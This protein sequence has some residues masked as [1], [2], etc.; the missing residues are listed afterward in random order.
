MIRLLILLIALGFPTASVE[1]GSAQE[2]FYK[3]KNIRIIVGAAAGGGYDTYSRTSVR[4]AK[5]E[6]DP[7]VASRPRWRDAISPAWPSLCG[8]VMSLCV[9]TSMTR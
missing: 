6:G 5:A 7:Q 8:G 9:W 3:D 1:L 2:A 4:S